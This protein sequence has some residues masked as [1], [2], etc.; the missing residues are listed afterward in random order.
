MSAMSSVVIDVDLLVDEEKH[1][2]RNIDPVLLEAEVFARTGGTVFV[3]S[4]TTLELAEYFVKQLLKAGYDF[5]MHPVSFENISGTLDKKAITELKENYRINPN[6]ILYLNTEE[7]IAKLQ[8]GNG[9]LTII[10][11]PEESDPAELDYATAAY[12]TARHQKFLNQ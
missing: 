2:F 11:K 9:V 3:Y 6:L 7:E 10:V 5:E 12:A 4:D 8:P 1:G